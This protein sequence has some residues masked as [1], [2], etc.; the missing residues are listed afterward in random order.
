MPGDP[1][2]PRGFKVCTFTTNGIVEG[3]KSDSF[4]PE[5]ISMNAI[6]NLLCIVNDLYEMLVESIKKI[7]IKKKDS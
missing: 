5:R 6:Y 1:G 7:K 4:F 3:R 2:G